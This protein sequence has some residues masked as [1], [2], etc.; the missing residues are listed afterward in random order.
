LSS[1]K[2]DGV[3]KTKRVKGRSDGVVD[4]QGVPLETTFTRIPAEV[5]AVEKT[6]AAIR[7]RRRHRAGRRDRN[8][9]A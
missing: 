9:S 3:G 7:V 8:L 5:K 6:L 1:E 4:G 2:G